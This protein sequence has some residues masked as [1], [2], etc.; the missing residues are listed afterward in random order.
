MTSA[1]LWLDVCL[2]GYLRPITYLRFKVLSASD[3][4][5]KIIIIIIIIWNSDVEP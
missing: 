1:L 2:R 5:K 3:L 4:F